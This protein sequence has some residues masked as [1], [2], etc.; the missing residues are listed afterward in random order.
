MSLSPRKPREAYVRVV[1]TSGGADCILG[2]EIR[3]GEPV[4]ALYN[5]AAAVMLGA[6]A[7]LSGDDWVLAEAIQHDVVMV[8]PDRAYFVEVSHDE[9]GKRWVQLFQPW[10]ASVLYDGS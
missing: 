5:Q 2:L 6:L 9:D 1:E 10:Q 3:P 4:E 8:W 7:S